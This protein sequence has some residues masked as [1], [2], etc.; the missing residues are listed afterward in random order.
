MILEYHFLIHDDPGDKYWAEGIELPGCLTQGDSLEELRQNMA[1]ALNLM[2]DEPDD[3]AVIHPLPDPK[4]KGNNIVLVKTTEEM[5]E[6]TLRRSLVN[7]D[8]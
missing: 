1:E 7:L 8:L 4:I 3:S 6:K 5:G 2:L